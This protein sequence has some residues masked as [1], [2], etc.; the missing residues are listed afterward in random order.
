MKLTNANLK[1]KYNEIYKNGAKNFFTFTTYT[2]SQLIMNEVK[3]WNNKEVLEI[4]CGEG[5]MASIIAYAGAKHV[6]AIDYSKEAINIASKKYNIDNV[7]FKVADAKDLKGSYDIVVL[8]G[9]LEHIDEPFETLDFIFNNLLKDNGVLITTSPS[10][11][12]PRGYIWMTLQL[13]LDVPMSLSDINFFSPYEFENFAQKNNS[14]LKINSTDHDWGGGERALVD[15]EKRLVNAL[16]DAGLDNTK[17]D[18]LIFWLANNMQYFENSNLTGVSMSYT[19]H[20]NK[21]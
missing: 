14:I 12:N 6:D 11:N 18:K 21:G 1:E 2:E 5:N 7:D 13:L 3:D 20:K 9:V 10:F 16:R 17:V 19:F 4:G 15:L 8:Q